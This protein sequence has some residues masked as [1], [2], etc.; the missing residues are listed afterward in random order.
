MEEY[1]DERIIKPMKEKERRELCLKDFGI[2][3]YLLSTM[4]NKLRSPNL[5][6]NTRAYAHLLCRMLIPLFKDNKW[7]STSEAM[8]A[9]NFKII[10]DALLK[11]GKIAEFYEDSDSYIYDLE[12]EAV[13]RLIS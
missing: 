13:S 7:S 9:K 10:Y 6:S 5:I 11:I 1:L 4:Y 2:R 8:V 3:K 12:N